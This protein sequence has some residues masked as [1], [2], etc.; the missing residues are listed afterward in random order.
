MRSNVMAV[1]GAAMALGLTACDK[2]EE[3][4]G[5]PI[6]AARQ[7]VGGACVG[8]DNL[9]KGSRLYAQKLDIDDTMATTALVALEPP[10]PKYKFWFI[11]LK[12]SDGLI[13]VRFRDMANV[14][15]FAPRARTYESNLRDGLRNGAGAR[16]IERAEGVVLEGFSAGSQRYFI[17]NNPEQT[18]LTCDT[19][20]QFRGPSCVANFNAE[21]EG[22]R[23]RLITTFAFDARLRYPQMIK[24]AEAM[25]TKSFVPCP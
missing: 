2:L 9:P 10:G 11:P 8:L 21:L 18:V 17:A 3:P 6:T 23:Y 14:P 12:K 20:D 1:A 4:D 19:A 15:V 22:R 13:S 5:E 25:V 24:G 16:S 7:L